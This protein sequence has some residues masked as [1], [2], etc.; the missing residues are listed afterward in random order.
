VTNT[1]PDPANLVRLLAAVVAVGLI[2]GVVG[3]VSDT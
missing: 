3:C 1:E 2:V